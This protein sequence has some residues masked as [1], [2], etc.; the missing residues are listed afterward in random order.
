MSVFFSTSA[1][2]FG[3]HTDTANSPISKSM[4]SEDVL[5]ERGFVNLTNAFGWFPII[6]GI[7]SGIA[8][9]VHANNLKREWGA[10]SV[11]N[12]YTDSLK[13]RGIAEICCAGP[14]LFIMDMIA[15]FGRMGGCISDT[16]SR[17]N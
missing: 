14:I 2:C 7:I 10:D 8:K 3:I 4:G 6:G 5:S 9:I 1:R 15:I 12:K 17:V 13:N 16:L 11:I